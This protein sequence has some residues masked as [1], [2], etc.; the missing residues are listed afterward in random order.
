M[1]GPAPRQ[2]QTQTGL[3]DRGG[4]SEGG[5]WGVSLVS[6]LLVVMY[7]YE[8]GEVSDQDSLEGAGW[9]GRLLGRFT[10]TFELV[11]FDY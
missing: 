2:G 11:G 8:T 9:L 5:G 3:E 10:K 6:E 1:R 7:S 4:R